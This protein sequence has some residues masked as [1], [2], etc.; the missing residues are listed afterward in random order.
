[1]TENE[2][3]V[4]LNLLTR[5]I[6]EDDI[7]DVQEQLTNIDLSDMS[8]AASNSL[9]AK[10]LAKTVKLRQEAVARAL[11]D[12]WTEY[13]F[14]EIQTP[15]IT[16]LFS[17]PLITTETLRWI[18]Q[19]YPDIT[20][21]RHMT[22]LIDNDSSPEIMQA[23]VK[24]TRVYP[25][26]S[27]DVYEALLRYC[28]D[29]KIIED[30]PNVVMMEFIKS[31]YEK[32]A[33]Y[34][35]KPSWIIEFRES[36]GSRLSDADLKRDICREIPIHALL[37]DEKEAL[38]IL[39]NG[40]SIADRQKVQN[41]YLQLPD[42]K[43]RE[44]LHAVSHRK[45]LLE[46]TENI[47]LYRIFGPSNLSWDIATIVNDDIKDTINPCKDHGGCRMFTCNEIEVYNN[48]MERLTD[49]EEE[50]EPVK[51]PLAWFRGNCDFCH[52]KIEK[53]CYAVRLPLTMG[54]WAGCYCSWEHVRDDNNSTDFLQEKMI[55][56]HEEKMKK[57]GIYDRM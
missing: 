28:N 53:P 35:P 37:L 39:T 27:V 13:N 18:T 12:K 31:E 10:L 11:I 8:L 42:E 52:R 44:L 55:I 14:M 20:F 33:P 43:K 45:R 17:L 30:Y 36:K 40:L 56:L 25:S 9:L 23:A 4:A 34:A 26:Q 50:E 48:E 15:I 5:A 3:I 21:I 19:L 51:D 49:P 1:M 41:G 2:G 24:L 6:E 38:D 7:K 16:Q 46:M 32:V 57:I 29:Q 47:E 54:A 22:S